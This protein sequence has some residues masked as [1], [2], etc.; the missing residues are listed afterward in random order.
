MTYDYSVQLYSVRT[1]IE[2]DPM[3]TLREL[4]QMGYAGVEICYDYGGFDAFTSTSEYVRN[5]LA[6]NGLVV[7]GYHTNFNHLQDDKLAV[8]MKYF[9]EVG[10]KNII[11]GTIRRLHIQHRRVEAFSRN[12]KRTFKKSKERRICTWLS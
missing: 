11:V 10:N 5:A 1:F 3:N 6:E 4:K 8:T 7:A 12:V 2:K 9:K